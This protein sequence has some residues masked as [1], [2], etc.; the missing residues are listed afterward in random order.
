MSATGDPTN[1]PRHDLHLGIDP[2]SR[3]NKVLTGQRLS[4]QP[5]W[6]ETQTPSTPR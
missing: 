4:D 2:H 1:R 3:F 5:A 6:T